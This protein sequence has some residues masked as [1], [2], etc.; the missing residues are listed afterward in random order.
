[1]L[2]SAFLPCACFVNDI[3]LRRHHDYSHGGRVESSTK[4]WEYGLAISP[5]FVLPIELLF[6]VL[7]LIMNAK[8]SDNDEEEWKG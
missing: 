1:M 2:T 3:H 4:K 8:G 7:F 6:Q 5:L